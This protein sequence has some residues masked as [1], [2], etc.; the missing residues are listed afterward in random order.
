MIVADFKAPKGPS[1]VTF[2]VE[3]DISLMRANKRV[4]RVLLESTIQVQPARVRVRSLV[5]Q[6]VNEVVIRRWMR[7]PWSAPVSA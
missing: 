1:I 4:K 6:I 7:Q 5:V 2:V 3:E